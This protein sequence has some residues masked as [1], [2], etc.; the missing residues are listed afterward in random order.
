MVCTRRHRAKD[1]V[2]GQGRRKIAGFTVVPGAPFPARKYGLRRH[3]ESRG[4]SPNDIGTRIWLTKREL[5]NISFG[6]CVRVGPLSNTR[7]TFALCGVKNVNRMNVSS[8]N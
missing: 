1:S 3:G 7:G 5:F 8:H 2:K 6:L 4:V